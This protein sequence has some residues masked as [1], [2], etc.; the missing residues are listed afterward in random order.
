MFHKLF[1]AC[2]L[3]TL[4]ACRPVDGTFSISLQA[5][6]PEFGSGIVLASAPSVIEQ[7][8]TV[9]PGM[10]FPTVT[11]QVSPTAVPSETPSPSATMT[12]TQRRETA[13]PAASS[14]PTTVEITTNTPRPSATPTQTLPPTATPT[15]TNT[16]APVTPI[17]NALQAALTDPNG[18]LLP[19]WTPPPA[20][21][22]TQIQD[23]FYMG[24][25][26]ADGATNWVDRTYP[27]GSTA[28]NRL[29]LH[30]GVEFVNPGGTPILAAEAGT[31]FYAGEDTSVVFGPQ[32]NYYG[33]LVVVQHTFTAPD[34]QPVFSLYGHMDGIEVTQGQPVSR[35]EQLGSVGASG[36]AL[37]AHLH[38]EVR[39]GD[40]YSFYA[41]RNPELWIRPYPTYGLL[42]GRTLDANGNRLYDVTIK[43]QS[44]RI[45]RYAFSYAG[46]AVNPD[47]VFGE[48]FTLGDL[49]ADYYEVSVGENGRVRFREIIYI[50]PNRTT[51]LDVQL[52]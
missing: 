51:W 37:G 32:P 40:P 14:T 44:A 13:A 50:Y 29:P 23:H 6:Q 4:A 3:V 20:D 34:G 2:C 1:L 33:R 36:V 5:T 12:R 43:V 45:T 17:T 24:R 15:V 31:V 49:P 52:N 48:H 18:T 10:Q 27:Y 19:T 25:P 11:P 26:I 28:G 16:A 47:T 9:R 30:H 41:T 46:D 22:T 7:V 8:A 35:G 39:V 42:A 38:F 21:P